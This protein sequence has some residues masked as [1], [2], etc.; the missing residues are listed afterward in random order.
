MSDTVNID[1]YELKRTCESCPE[2]YD[3]FD[4]DGAM[5]GYLRLRNGW[6]RADV[7]DCGGETV[8]QYWFLDDGLKGSFT[9]EERPYYLKQA[10][11]AIDAWR[12]KNE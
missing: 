4:S 2:Q 1:G 11:A 12:S 5:V 7:P 8:Y 6:F 3:V 10:I 9:D